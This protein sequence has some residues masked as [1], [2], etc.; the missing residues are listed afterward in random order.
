[1]HP[2]CPQTPDDTH[3]GSSA[4]PP[5]LALAAAASVLLTSLTAPVCA[6]PQPRLLE[7]VLRPALLTPSPAPQ[8]SFLYAMSHHP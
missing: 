1:M 5:A 4:Q 2:P 6:L 8:L 3:A 7:T